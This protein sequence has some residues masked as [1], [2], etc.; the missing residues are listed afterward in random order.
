MELFNAVG[1]VAR[2]DQ[3]KA[4]DFATELIKHLEAKGLAVFLEPR[5]AEYAKK[6]DDA[7]SLEK[8]KTD[9]IITVGGDGTILRTCLL[10]PKPEPPILAIN[11]G[12][13]GFLAEVPPEKGF[14]AVDRCLDGEF[15]LERCM[16][17][18]SSIGD[19]RLPDA[20]NEV[21]ITSH[22]PAKLLYARIWKDETAVA[23]CRAD[24]M[25]VASQVGS[26]G[27]SLSAGGPV[28]DPDLAAF[29]FTP[30]CPLTVFH[31][32]V[33]SAENAVTIE[34]LKPKRAVVVLDGHYRTEMEP[35]NP[36]IRVSKSEYESSF[37]RFGNGFYRRLKSRL[38]FSRS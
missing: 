19:K 27:Y 5:L 37:V 15:H 32:M 6:T 1:I 4:L 22:A 14:D 31:P 29:V 20:L 38:L 34:L 28:L 33:L 35:K 26:T 16:K 10:I 23:E 8:M 2:V 21:L 7:I 17:L 30:V 12:V 24:G 9:L 3:K 11:M 13:R 36:R 18:A 25:I